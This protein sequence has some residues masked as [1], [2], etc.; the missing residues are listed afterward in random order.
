MCYENICVIVSQ[1]R[2]YKSQQH[3]EQRGSFGPFQ[4]VHENSYSIKAFENTLL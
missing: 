3:I 4:L 2:D 1:F